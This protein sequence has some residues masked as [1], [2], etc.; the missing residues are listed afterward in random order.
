MKVVFDTNVYISA[1]VLPGSRA[2]IALQRIIGGQDQLLLSRPILAELLDV[3]ARK[4]SRD[5]EELSRVALFL[6]DLGTIVETT[7]TVHELADDPDN[8]ILEC[9]VDGGAH[10]VV[11][12]DR[13]MLQLETWRGIRMMSLAD[14]L[15]GLLPQ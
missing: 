2:D 9:A 3:L 6:D 13:R 5:A 7:T 14:Y 12:G 8:R 1:L 4:F 10:C 11:T 15:G